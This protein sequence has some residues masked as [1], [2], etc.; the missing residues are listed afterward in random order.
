MNNEEIAKDLLAKIKEIEKEES[1]N[2]L[3]KISQSDQKRFERDVVGR[4]L[5]ELDEIYLNHEES[6]G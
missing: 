4:I 5:A 6:E 2:Y 3:G 1:K